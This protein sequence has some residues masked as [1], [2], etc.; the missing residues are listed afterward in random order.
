MVFDLLLDDDSYNYKVRTSLLSN[1]WTHI[2]LAC[3]T[4]QIYQYVC[5]IEVATDIQPIYYPVSVPASKPKDDPANDEHF[6]V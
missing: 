3:T 2:G 4:N 1:A 5:V 6:Y